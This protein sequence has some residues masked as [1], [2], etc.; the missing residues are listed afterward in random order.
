[1]DLDWQTARTRR[2]LMWGVL[3]LGFF[4]VSFN[5]VTTGVLAEDLTRAFGLTATELSVLH[6]SFFYI[7]ALLLKHGRC[8]SPP[9]R[10][11]A[12]LSTGRRSSRVRNSPIS[13]IRNR[14][15]S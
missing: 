14:S 11:N 10:Q 13:M 15:G 6:S 8:I 5:R 1:M 3:A 12:T 7:Y 4:L 9:N 2:W